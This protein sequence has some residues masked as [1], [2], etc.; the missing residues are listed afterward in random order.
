[1]SSDEPCEKVIIS[2]A[3]GNEANEEEEEKKQE[4]SSSSSTAAAKQNHHQV[5]LTRKS[6]YVTGGGSI[7][8]GTPKP[9]VVVKSKPPTLPQP[10]AAPHAAE[11]PKLP[12]KPKLL[13]KKKVPSHNKSPVPTPRKT[14]N[15]N[16]D[17]LV[18]AECY[19]MEADT[20]N[21]VIFEVNA[22]RPKEHDDEE[23]EEE[24][25]AKNRCKNKEETLA[26]IRKSLTLNE[27]R[28]STK[29]NPAP[30][31]PT[32][33]TTTTAT[34]TAA[35]STMNDDQSLLNHHQQQ[36]PEQQQGKTSVHRNSSLHHQQQPQQQQQQ[37]QQQQHVKKAVQF[38]PDITVAPR[39]LPPSTYALPFTRQQL[40]YNSWIT[41]NNINNSNSINVTDSGRV[42]ESS[43][44][45]Q[46]IQM[47]P[48]DLTPVSLSRH[49]D[50]AHR[51][52]SA[53]VVP[54][55][56]VGVGV[57]GVT[58]VD[59]EVR[60]WT[61][62]KR[63]KSVQ[64]RGSEI[65]EIMGSSKTK[66]KSKLSFPLMIGGNSSSNNNG[67][68]N[69]GNQEPAIKRHSRVEL[70]E[71]DRRQI[72]QR[73][74]FSFS[75]MLR[76]FSSLSSSSNNSPLT[77]SSGST[78]STSSNGERV[79][80]MDEEHRREILERERVKIRPNTALAPSVV[81]VEVVPIRPNPP[82]G[83]VTYQKHKQP[84]K[85]TKSILKTRV[86]YQDS[87]DSGHETSSI[88]TDNSDSSGII[89][90]ESSSSSASSTTSSSQV[91][92]CSGAHYMELIS[93]KHCPE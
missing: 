71:A 55:A 29:R 45:G 4:S 62:K 72:S 5:K 8:K 38:N 2:A 60:R 33:T 25:E 34:T 50:S 32:T 68:N 59:D 22:T 93:C 15:N 49:P 61:E 92:A 35:T 82:A 47:L 73:N 63:S 85:A 28:P 87:K 86:E 26:Q 89:E 75:K 30:R 14:T 17:K 7:L 18:V 67:S 54:V 74:R 79:S 58:P 27:R 3:C 37:Q 65:D 81:E 31:P 41:H 44:T 46:P 76:Q 40:A 56:G 83:H 64:P 23:K 53:L 10:P 84:P 51:R 24:K 69:N 52:K 12:E 78:P 13:L 70:Y 19:S 88:H 42:I 16:N 48:E 80:V 1:M 77:P 21:E 57:G 39:H 11:K 43:F 9:V 90:H 66:T 91:R 6:P 20:Q 36:Q